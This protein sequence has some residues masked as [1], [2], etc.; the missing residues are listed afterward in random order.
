[1]NKATGAQPL[2][3]EKELEYICRTRYIPFAVLF[4]LTYRCN[5]SCKH[6]YVIDQGRNELSCKE[7]K[8]ILDH[9]VKRVLS[10]SAGAAAKFSPGEIALISCSMPGV[11]VSSKYY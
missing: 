5:L 8:T 6:C 3:I 2:S 9:L 7:I 1:M 4:E 10:I 11:R